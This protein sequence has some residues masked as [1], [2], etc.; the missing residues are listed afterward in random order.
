MVE[1]PVDLELHTFRSPTLASVVD[2]AVGF[3]ARTPVHSLPP[4][5]SFPGVGVYMLYYAGDY[6]LY[7]YIARFNESEAKR[8]IYV[9]K[10]VPPGWRTAR[11]PSDEKTPALYGRLG[12]HARSI[13]EG[14]G[15]KTEHFQCRFMVLGGIE[16]D[17]VTAIEAKLI[18]V[19]TPLW[20]THV[21][22]FGNHD[23]GKGRYNQAPSEWDVLHPGRVWAAR[24]TGTPPLREEILAKIRR[25]RQ[26][27]LSLP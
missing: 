24:L 17:L 3:V 7:D 4:A 27:Q 20:N 6:Q 16:T 12:Q 13:K 2:D 21:E 9:G 18:R 10:A 26:Q 1:K 19:H 8:P 15:L 5:K 22:G 11:A 25:H 23:P 14:A